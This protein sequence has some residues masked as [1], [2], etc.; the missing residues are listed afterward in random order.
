MKKLAILAMCGALSAFATSLVG[1]APRNPDDTG[2]ISAPRTW[3]NVDGI[4]G[5]TMT[6]RGFEL[7]SGSFVAAN[8]THFGATTIGMGVC[9]VAP[10]AENCSGDGAGSYQWQIDNVSPGGRDFVLFTF[11][12]PVYLQNFT[13]TQTTVSADSDWSWWTSPNLL[14]GTPAQIATALTAQTTGGSALTNVDGPQFSGPF[15]P[16]Y[17]QAT[18]SIPMATPVQSI[19]IGA[20]PVTGTCPTTNNPSTGN[21][22]DCNLFK[23]VSIN[24]SNVPEPSS[25]ALLGSGLAGLGVAAYRRRKKS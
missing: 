16:P 20:G 14:T 12:S 10:N 9:G 24:V 21:L 13:I 23:L 6:V 5:L 15:S 22:T 25:V 2:S 4:A 17:P 11:S 19:L 18:F 7:V 3:S 1:T 8:T